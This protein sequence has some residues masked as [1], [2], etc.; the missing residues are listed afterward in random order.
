MRA[1]LYVCVDACIRVHVCGCLHAFVRILLASDILLS[2]MY[3]FPVCLDDKQIY[4][5]PT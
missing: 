2:R 5:S 3:A 4:R 1:C